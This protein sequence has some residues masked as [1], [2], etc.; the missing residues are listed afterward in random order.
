M[1]WKFKVATQDKWSVGIV[2]SKRRDN[3]MENRRT[4]KSACKW[5][6]RIV[7]V[8]MSIKTWSSSLAMKK[9]KRLRGVPRYREAAVMAWRGWENRYRVQKHNSLFCC[10]GF[11]TR[12]KGHRF[13]PALL[14]YTPEDG[15]LSITQMEL[16]TKPHSRG[17]CVDDNGSQSYFVIHEWRDR[18]QANG[19]RCVCVMCIFSPQSS[20]NKCWRP[21]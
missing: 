9:N 18:R 2:H 11:R 13:V 17:S 7:S 6:T 12:L 21:F 16:N 10:V 14:Y 3:Y 1:H 20:A 15:S 4:P 19:H 8:Y 5:Y